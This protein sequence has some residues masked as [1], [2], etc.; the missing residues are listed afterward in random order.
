MKKIIKNYL[1]FSKKEA[2]AA[3]VIIAIA[4]LFICLPYIFSAKKDKQPVDTSLAKTAAAKVIERDS[5]VAD[6]VETDYKSSYNN[7]F[8]SKKNASYTITPFAFDPNTIDENGWHKL[9]LPDKVIKT[10]LNYRS[11]GG[12]FKSAE[13]IRKIWGLKKEDA[14]ELIPF[15]T[16]NTKPIN[17]KFNNTYSNKTYE[18]TAPSIVE[19]NTASVDDFK[20]LP[21]VGNTAYKIVKFREKLGGF[22]SINQIK[23]TYGLTDSVYQAMQPFLALSNVHIQKININ[24]TSDFDLSK[25][26]YISNDIAKAIVIY[27]K[28]HGNFNKIE[29]VKKIVFIN[30][31]MYQKIAPYITVD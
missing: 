20:R 30:Q 12:Y 17:N 14:D 16:I 7:N 31:Q 29:D 13:D 22:I 15:I 3:F 11:K 8:E 18:K 9:G 6:F 27:R 23:E 10:I 19:I 2:I 28:Q 21:G 1:T 24:T 26:P 4:L 5:N 25:H